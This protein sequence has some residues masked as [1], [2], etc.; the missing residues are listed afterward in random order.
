MSEGRREGGKKPGGKGS[1][2]RSGGWRCCSYCRKTVLCVCVCVLVESAVD[3]QV[4][5]K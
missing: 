2:G 3:L 5:S 1:E 4:S